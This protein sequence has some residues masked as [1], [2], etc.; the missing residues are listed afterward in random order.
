MYKYAGKHSNRSNLREIGLKGAEERPGLNMFRD[1]SLF[2][3]HVQTESFPG[4]TQ[5]LVDFHVVLWMWEHVAT[6]NHKISLS[7]HPEAVKPA[8]KSSIKGLMGNGHIDNR[9]LPNSASVYSWPLKRSDVPLSS[10]LGLDKPFRRARFSRIWDGFSW[11]LHW[12]TPELKWPKSWKWKEE[13]VSCLGKYLNQVPCEDPKTGWPTC[14]KSVVGHSRS[15]IETGSGS[16]DQW[17]SRRPF[18]RELRD[19]SHRQRSSGLSPGAG[20]RSSQT[21]WEKQK[22]S[23][24]NTNTIIIC[25]ICSEHVYLPNTGLVVLGM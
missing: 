1:K 8:D 9:S 17:W 16:P 25:V 7:Q 22:A 23:L 24:R 20:N 15:C 12:L 14:S 18:H 2:S 5:M 4:W 19:H 21:S 13:N 3:E 11:S 6:L 10:V